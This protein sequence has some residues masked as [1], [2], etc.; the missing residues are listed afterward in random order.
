MRYLT[1]AFQ[2]LYHVEK[3]ALIIYPSLEMHK[4]KERQMI[5]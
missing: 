4:I 2:T 5:F 3:L 1:V